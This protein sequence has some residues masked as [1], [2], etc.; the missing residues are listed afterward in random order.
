MK[1]IIS[2]ILTVAMIVSV[3][4][5]LPAYAEDA[6]L[7]GTDV[8]L[9]DGVLLNF[10][11]E[12]DENAD[13]TNATPT[14]KDGKDCY[15]LTCELA[16]K[17]MG[18]TVTAELKS[19][20]TT[21]GTYT[22]SVKEYA[23]GI[24][25]GSY[26]SETK[27][28]VS[29]MLGYGAAAQKYFGYKTNALVGSPAASTDKLDAA[30]APAHSISDPS[31][32]YIGAALVLEGTMKLRFYFE[33]D[34]AISING[35]SVT[36]VVGDELCYADVAITPDEID[37]QFEVTCDDAAVKYGVI[38]Y[39]KNQADNAALS[40]IVAS[41]YDYSL[42][43]ER[44]IIAE[45]CTHEGIEL[46]TVQLPTI[47]N[48]GIDSGICPTC[49]KT[50]TEVSDK[51]TANEKKI[52]S[53]SNSS[54]FYS[55]GVNI[56]TDVLAG[57]K[58]FY[59]HAENGYEGRDLYIEFSFLY[60]ETLANNTKGMIDFFRFE[61]SEGGNGNTVYFM[62]FKDQNTKDWY[63]PYAGSF[64]TGDRIG[65][66]TVSQADKNATK[67]SHSIIS[68][69]TM[70][71]H[72]QINNETR[73][74]YVFIGDYGWHR[75]GLR[76]HQEATVNNGSV[77][78]TIT[79]H[80]YIDGELVSEY[81]YAP[82]TGNLLFT[83]Q[84]VGGEVVY[85]DIASDRIVYYYKLRDAK[86]S[87][88]YLVTAD[89]Y[90]TAGNGFV[91]DVESVSDPDDATYETKSGDSLDADAY[92]ALKGL[93]DGEITEENC[94]HKNVNLSASQ[95]ATI[96][97]AGLKEG[98]C[99]LCGKEFSEITPKTEPVVKK[100]NASTSTSASYSDGVN[101]ANDILGGGKHFYPHAENGYEG[102]DLFVEFSFL[103]NETLNKN[104][105]GILDI[106]RIEK[107]DKSAG[108]SFYF[109]NMKNNTGWWCPYEG[110]F[111]TGDRRNGESDYD[112]DII[113]GPTMPD[114]SKVNG[115]TKDDYLFIG[116]Y[117]WHRLG[118]QVHQEAEI[119]NNKVVY[120]VAVYFYIDGDAVSAYYMDLTQSSNDLL[121]TATIDGNSLVYKD[122]DADKN[123]LFY[124][125]RNIK[126]DETFYL[127]TA[128]HYAT[129]GDGFVLDVKKVA[130]PEE[131]IFVTESGDEFVGDAHYK[132]KNL[133]EVEAP[134]TSDDGE[135]VILVSIDGL[136]PD[137]LANT[138]YL[139]VLKNMATY[140]VS[141]QTINPSVTMPAHT[142]MFHSVPASVHGLYNNN[143]L[144][145]AS[146]GN[147][148]TETLL[149]Q[150]KTVAMFFDYENMQNLTT[151]YNQVERNY[152]HWYKASGEEY[153][154][155]STIE[156]CDALLN[157]VEN[158]PTDFTYVYFG[159]TDQMGHDYNW[160]SDKYYM[161]IEHI[162]DNLLEVIFRLPENY[163][164]IITSDHG[165]GGDNG[166]NDH[167]STNPV[168]MTIPL[169][170]IGERYEDDKLIESDVSIL[171]V[172]PT[173]AYVLGVEAEKYWVGKPLTEE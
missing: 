169:F 85:S 171:D 153:H 139:E 96:F 47:F 146:L 160:L 20:N 3:L 117:G 168:D 81:V 65:D 109:L 122:I 125:I 8:T 33:G 86:G 134:K 132:L 113:Y 141:A 144:T 14:V 48:V 80:F 120:T 64:E 77:S 52:N 165:G 152:I 121:Y 88:Q 12:A 164:V 15:K 126:S 9:T 68:G 140:T 46:E 51:T 82:A 6:K 13:V 19:G 55:E 92:Y 49:G 1:K 73:D 69:P 103:Y 148:I 78:Y 23:E 25:S 5:V 90:V 107:V 147:G 87:M 79:A 43:A 39:L 135:K 154:E 112:I 128:D 151:A 37:E 142:S 74:D 41:I 163:T 42:A 173:V 102:R 116:D 95:P 172:A 129:A 70:P 11:I 59:P 38:N 161:A 104:L 137:A 123:M 94:A 111:E 16:A 101:F 45:N 67:Y 71:D 36:T 21:L 108:H 62:Q 35:K 136:R 124:K 7:I 150:G 166:I 50:V 54:A 26:S 100:Y 44:Y 98:T 18:D 158:D 60:N 34:R 30:N 115:E 72:Y 97:N 127:M 91:L 145:S 106:F 93:I 118:I 17:E 4:A 84:V 22:Y 170:I 63:A 58:H 56:A 10:Y 157:H 89:E 162:F 159:M 76:L 29:A 99:A 167:G 149:A 143:F 130:D 32:I 138:D 105:Y 40:E 66:Q 61:N 28:L 110:G 119:K 57:E 31:D 27:A 156:L 131:K 24:L 114:Y 53:S 2:F 75:L 155:R 133:T 83:A